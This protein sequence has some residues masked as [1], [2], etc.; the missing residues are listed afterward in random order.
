MPGFTDRLTI[1]QAKEQ[2]ALIRMFKNSS[3]KPG[4]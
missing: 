2:V 3:E 1:D 4:E